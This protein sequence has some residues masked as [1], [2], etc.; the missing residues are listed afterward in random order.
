MRAE[1]GFWLFFRVLRW[2]LWLSAIA[3]YVEFT[4]HRHGHLNQFGHLLHTTEFWMFGLPVAAIFAG[5]FELMMR[6][7][8]GL[9]RPSP[10]RGWSLRG[11]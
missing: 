11:G 5:F 2:I 8:S 9:S 4:L 1:I 3:Y 6:E 10:F 7:R